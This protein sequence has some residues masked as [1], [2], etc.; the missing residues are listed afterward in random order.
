MKPMYFFIMMAVG[1]MNALEANAL[2]VQFECEM[3]VETDYNQ[4]IVLQDYESVVVAEPPRRKPA[5]AEE[6]DLAVQMFPDANK[7]IRRY[8]TLPFRYFLTPVSRRR[9]SG[10]MLVEIGVYRT[11]NFAPHGREVV[12]SSTREVGVGEE[13][14][15]EVSFHYRALRELNVDIV[16]NPG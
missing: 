12:Y 8:S 10:N 13:G 16:C 3:T 7:K 15:L 6:Q 9:S 2:E 14:T 4:R 1:A 11:N 5:N